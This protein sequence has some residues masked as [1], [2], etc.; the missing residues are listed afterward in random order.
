MSP[1]AIERRLA[2]ILSADV[3]GYSRLMADDEDATVRTI[4]AYR[5]LIMLLIRQSN[6]RVVDSPGDELLAEFPSAVDAVRCAVEIQRV[7]RARNAE[8]P[9]ARRMEFRLGLDLGDVRVDGERIYGHGVNLAA[10]LRALARPREICIS[11]AVRDQIEGKLELSYEDLGEHSVKNIAKPLHV[12]AVGIDVTDAAAEGVASSGGAI[13][14]LAVL[15]LENLSPDP[16]QDILVDG[17]TEALISDLAKIRS[18][19]VVSRTTIL[20]YKGAR[21]PLPEIARELRVEGVIEGSVAREED[22]VRVTVQL[23]DARDDSHIWVERYDRDVHG[24]LALQSEIART[25]ADQIQLELTPREEELLAG[26]LGRWFAR[27][28]RTGVA[29][30]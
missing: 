2:A 24:V 13:R 3:V 27:V 1:E 20:Q 12:Y 17:M 16:D 18:L 15:P 10:R 4:S 23:I 8:L 28:R 7:L 9:T 25:V 22:R 6:G 21:K 19:R 11:A 14:A 29:E 30:D 26:P 5:D